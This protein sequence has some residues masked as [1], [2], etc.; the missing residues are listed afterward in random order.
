MGFYCQ[1]NVKIQPEK[2][3]LLIME[4]GSNRMKKRILT[5]ALI[6]TLLLAVTGCGNKSEITISLDGIGDYE[7]T[8]IPSGLVNYSTNDNVITVT[9]KKNGNYDFKVKDEDGK[10]YSFTLKYENKK[11]EAQTDD[12]I[13][14]NLGMK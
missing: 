2:A 9:V 10:E 7:V 6:F 12:D 3:N 1:K 4:R 11:V 5:A 8:E 13:A 14:V